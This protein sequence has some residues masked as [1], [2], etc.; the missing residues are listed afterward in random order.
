MPDVLGLA[1]T[2]DMLG[3]AAQLLRA[4]GDAYVVIVIRNTPD[5]GGSDQAFA[6]N[7]SIAE[8]VAALRWLADDT[9]RRLRDGGV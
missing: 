7:L 8:V 5:Q 2:V 6:S 4:P 1:E 9:E 3:K